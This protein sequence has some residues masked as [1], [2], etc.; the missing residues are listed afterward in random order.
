[1]GGDVEQP[2]AMVRSDLMFCGDF[3]A[4]RE[5]AAPRV[6]GR[7]NGDTRHAGPAD[8]GHRREGNQATGAG[9]GSSGTVG[10]PGSVG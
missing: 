1:M 2:A 8:A 9:G 7:I 6:K 3:E 5:T 10:T 4:H